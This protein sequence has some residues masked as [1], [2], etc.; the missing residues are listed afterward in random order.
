MLKTITKFAVILFLSLGF[1]VANG[2]TYSGGTGTIADPFQIA[3]LSD[4]RDLSTT[5]GH[6]DKHFKQIANIDA[7]GTYNWNGGLGFSPIGNTILGFNG[8]YKCINK[9]I[10]GLTIFNPNSEYIG[11]FGK[12][13]SATIS[14]VKLLE[15]SITGGNM[16]GGLIGNCISGNI[17]DCIINAKIIGTST[18]SGLIGGM[19]GAA[20][21]T[22]IIN[23]NFKGTVSGNKSSIGGLV[24]TLF[25][26]NL[27][28]SF[29]TGN[30]NGFDGNIGGFVGFCIDTKINN[31]YSKCNVN[32]S[33]NY[34]GGLIGNADNSNI[35]NCYSTGRVTVDNDY[36]IGGFV[37]SSYITTIINCYSIGEVIGGTKAKGFIG[38]KTIGSVSNCF[39]DTETS[40]ILSSAGGVGKTTTEMKNI[41]TF[42]NQGWD[43]TNETSNGLLD[44][45]KTEVCNNISYPVLYWQT[46]LQTEI[47][48]QPVN[49]TVC[50]HASAL[51]AV[52][53]LGDNLSYEWSN[54][55]TSQLMATSVAGT[56]QVTVSGTCGSAVSNSFSLF[57]TV[58]GTNATITSAIILFPS[59]V[60]GTFTGTNANLAWHPLDGATTYCIRYARTF[61]FTTT[62]QTICGLT[63]ANYL[64]VLSAAGLR[65]EAKND[66]IYYQ[67]AGVDANG[68]RSQWSAKQMF[69]LRTE[70][71]TSVNDKLL[72]VNDKFSIIPNP[73]TG[74]FSVISNLPTTNQEL[75]TIYN[76]LG[77]IVHTQKLV[78]E[79]TEVK[80]N[81]A[82]GVYLVKVG[83]QTSRLV[84]W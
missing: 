79:S 60:T 21:A 47:Q 72:S 19:I 58:C 55:S 24:G 28:N 78:S 67:V 70:T 42:I 34:V 1:G 6:W 2:Q 84:V 62:V 8:S 53:A 71:S 41:N 35:N 45:W 66:T 29:T 7:R 49:A 20:T 39:W 76:S 40:G 63:S 22:K 27:L 80:A 38:I 16:L 3:N 52:S 10:L 33:N 15:S 83:T 46:I 73:T 9:F 81:L 56:Y 44:I 59:S 61:N 14:G 4:L 37:G 57:N 32:G 51:F 69:V 13:V 54:G 43:F 18:V 30:I 11:M 65:T 5:T 77:S 64:F 75:L 50:S 17:I 48:L 68:N 31:C 23:C 25:T 36:Y 82:K 12:V 26:C 74:E